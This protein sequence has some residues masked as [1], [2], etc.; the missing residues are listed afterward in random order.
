[1]ILH[2]NILEPSY[3]DDKRKDLMRALDKLNKKPRQGYGIFCHSGINKEWE[4]RRAKL[5]PQYTTK[6]KDIP[7][8]N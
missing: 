4:M 6:W 3:L 7:K 1:M 8:V 5:S 2:L